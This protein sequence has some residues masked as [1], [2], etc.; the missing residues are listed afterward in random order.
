MVYEW[1]R[2]H[3]KIFFGVQIV[4]RVLKRD[5]EFINT[6]TNWGNEPDY[7]RIVHNGDKNSGS[8]VYIIT[9]Q[10]HGYGFFAEFR[11][12]LE[13]L[14][15]ADLHG[16]IPYISW[17]KSYLYYD[18]TIN[19]ETNNVFNYYF[20][21]NNEVINPFESENIIFSRGCDCEY[22]ERKYDA[23]GYN[24]SW[25]FEQQLAFMFNKY[26]AIKK[27]I[28]SEFN[29]SIDKMFM[30]NKVLGVHYRGTDF[31]IGYNNHPTA[32]RLEQT[33]KAIK[34]AMIGREFKLIFLA[35]DEKGVYDILY[36]EFGNKVVW[37]DDTYRGEDSKSIAFSDENREYHHYKLGKEVLRDAYTLSKCEGLIAG[38]SQVS[39]GARIFKIRRNEV[40]SYCNIIDNGINKNNKMFIAPK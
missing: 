1:L 19:L 15:F 35:T 6:I 9:E 12:L 26:I 7:V 16:F 8:T 18:E 34:E 36:S 32:V 33:I 31:K 28:I 29:E 25:K 22:I 2:K 10:G 23:L 24:Q 38:M 37:F 17:S 27:D 4:Y 14:L 40:Y 11:C 13:K 5:T 39:F 20:E 21:M 3:K 30:N